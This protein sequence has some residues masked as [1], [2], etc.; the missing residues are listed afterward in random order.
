M[1]AT[2]EN[3]AL[4]VFHGAAVRLSRP[5]MYQHETIDRSVVHQRARQFRQ[6]TERFLAG[7]LSEDEFRPLRL[8]NGLYIQRHAPMLQ[9]AIPYG[10]LNA[11]Q[12]RRLAHIAREYDSG[13]GRLSTCRN[14][15]YRCPP[16]ERVPDILDELAEV[17][18]HAIQTSDNCCFN[19]M[20]DHF[21]GVA[22]DE[23]LDPRVYAEIIRQWSTL[24]PE[25]A[26]LPRE[27]KIALSGS[28][29]DRAAVMVQDIGLKAVFDYDGRPGFTV[30]VG[31]VLG[32]API[33]GHMIREFLPAGDLLTYLDAILRVYNLHGRRD[34]KYKARIDILVKELGV[35]EF[36]RQVAHEWSFLEGG[37]GTLPAAEIARVAGRFTRPP[38][39]PLPQ[40]SAAHEQHLRD[41]STFARWVARNVHPHRVSGYAAVKISLKKTGV[42][43]GNVM[44]TQ[45][46]DMA[47]LADRHSFGELRLTDEQDVVFADVE[48]ESLHALW[49]GLDKSEQ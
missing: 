22:P 41:D 12:L 45:M 21:A 35:A 26:R 28:P 1:C 39:Q 15:H 40:V 10:M 36:R 46:D 18:L 42:P 30:V 29:G 49:V 6:Q 44:A 33:V 4:S 38:Y 14:I 34:D 23:V 11:V 24:H 31:G 16:L 32:P 37:S 5:S 47:D 43:P 48:R 9:V 13:Y 25:F 7:T 27:F 20:V 19:T 17:D 2:G 3:R 8:Q